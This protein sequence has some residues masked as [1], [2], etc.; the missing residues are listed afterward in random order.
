MS[1]HEKH[2]QFVLTQQNNMQSDLLLF[3]FPSFNHLLS[4][5]HDIQIMQCLQIMNYK[6]TWPVLSID[7]GLWREISAIF[8]ILCHSVAAKNY[9]CHSAAAK[10][11]N[12]ESL[13]LGGS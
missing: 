5:L 8:H 7:M 2:C 13:H 6:Q 3:I 10:N 4:V 12:W 1:G 11:Y 9:F